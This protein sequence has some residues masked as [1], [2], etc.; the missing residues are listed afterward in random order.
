MIHEQS[1]LRREIY[2]QPDVITKLFNLEERN[3]Q[4]IAE[5][6]KQ[7]FEYV[8]IAARGSS[9]N[10]ARYA[11][12]LFGAHNH[13]PV[14]LAT[15]SLFTIYRESPRLAGAL[16]IG[17]S[18]SGQSPDI[19]KVIS[20]ANKQN[21]PTIAITN[22]PNSPLANAADH[23]IPLH[24][25]EELAVAASK[26][27]SSSLV[28]L[29]LISAKLIGNK[30]FSDQLHQLPIQISTTLPKVEERLDRVERYRYMDHCAVI[31]RGMNYATAFEIALKVKELTKTV[32][33]PYSSADFRH[34]PIAM[35]QEGFPVIVISPTGEV[36]EDVTSLIN[37]LIH[38]KSE[39][40]LISDDQ[41]LLDTAHLSFDIPSSIPEWLSPIVAVIP[42]QL[43][44]FTL[45]K[46]K[47]LDPDQPQ[48]IHKITE[49]L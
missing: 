29:A 48:G 23:V 13:V 40:I 41:K 18:Q 2:E 30:V 38:R 42:G 10:A 19:V 20:E 1:I 44:A 24:A 4:I 5:K 25:G 35:V 14:A 28:A 17:I 43:F 32:A 46:V 22:N 11:Q 3:I 21:R 16:V 31:G 26:T 39:L 45:A 9:D 36:S 33:E 34:G 27:Y 7:T 12:Y 15:P 6:I 49:T 37:E 47:G 8:L